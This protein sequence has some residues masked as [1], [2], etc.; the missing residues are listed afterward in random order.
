MKENGEREKKEEST[1]GLIW[2]KIKRI[3]L[4]KPPRKVTFHK[5]ACIFHLWAS[6]YFKFL[7]PCNKNNTRK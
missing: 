7:A 2:L 1:N 6:Q 3:Y 5:V 4:Q